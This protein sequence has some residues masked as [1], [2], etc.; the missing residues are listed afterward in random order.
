MNIPHIFDLN[1]FGMGDP[2]KLLATIKLCKKHCNNKN[3]IICI[4]ESKVANLSATQLLILEQF[5]LEYA[6]TPS[7]SKSGGLITIWSST[8]R[9]EASYP[10]SSHMNIYFPSLNLNLV[11][12]YLSPHDYEAK[13]QRVIKSV[14]KFPVDSTIVVTG[15]FN[16]FSH[17]PVNTSGKLRSIDRRIT[18]YT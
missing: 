3:F 18:R 6:L 8:L 4:Q 17:D 15:D 5:K 10:S 16:C 11:N 13:V 14:K 12:C 9:G 7:V 1:S 2:D